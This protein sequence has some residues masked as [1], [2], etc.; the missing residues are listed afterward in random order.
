MASLKK[1]FFDIFNAISDV[2]KVT[3]TDLIHFFPI[4]PFSNPWKHQN[5]LRFSDILRGY[6][7][8][9]LGTNGL[10]KKKKGEG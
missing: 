9:A 2:F 5:T 1:L 4:Y 6:R 3:L 7:K 8:G 10:Q